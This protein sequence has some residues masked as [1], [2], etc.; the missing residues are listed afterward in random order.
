M[1]VQVLGIGTVIPIISIRL[2]KLVMGQHL[3]VCSLS[4][5]AYD[6]ILGVINKLIDKETILSPLYLIIKDMAR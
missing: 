4:P 1:Y 5:W 2:M 6:L 3:D